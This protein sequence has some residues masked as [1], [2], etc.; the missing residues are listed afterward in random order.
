[1]K[2]N[3]PL[4]QGT[5]APYHPHPRW[6]TGYFQVLEALGVEQQRHPFYAHWVRQFFNQYQGNRRRRDLGERNSPPFSNG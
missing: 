5:V 6:P 2:N 4:R 3:Q 1:M